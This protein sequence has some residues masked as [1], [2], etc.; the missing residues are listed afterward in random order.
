[1]GSEVMMSQ[2]VMR[3]MVQAGVQSKVMVF[4]RRF[5]SGFTISAKPGMKGHWNP[6]IPSMLLTSLMDFRVVS[7][8]LTSGKTSHA[9]ES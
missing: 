9:N 8:S 7:H 4:F 6:R 5:I 3:A 1:M 2:R